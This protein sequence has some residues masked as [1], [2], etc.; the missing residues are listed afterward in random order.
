MESKRWWF[1]EKDKKSEIK[2]EKQNKSKHPEIKNERTIKVYKFQV[3]VN[4]ELNLY[5][6]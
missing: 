5:G 3:L 1:C 2:I 6:K 4:F